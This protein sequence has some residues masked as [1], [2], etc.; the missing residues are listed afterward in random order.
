MQRRGGHYE[1]AASNGFSLWEWYNSRV[2]IYT[3]ICNEYADL[4]LY[5][6]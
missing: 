6:L 2:L 1:D 4:R 5:G 3:R